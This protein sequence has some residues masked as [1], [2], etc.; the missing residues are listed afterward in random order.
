MSGKLIMCQGLPGSG[1]TTWANEQV[2]A[3][4][5]AQFVPWPNVVGDPVRYTPN[6]VVVCRDDIRR[7]LYAVNGV[8]SWR[9]YAMTPEQE[10][11]VTLVQRERIGNAL[12]AGKAV[13]SADTNISHRARTMLS[14]LA[15]EFGVTLEVKQFL[16]DPEECIRR[17]ALRGNESVGADVIR[18]MAKQ[19]GVFEEPKVTP[20]VCKH[21]V[22]DYWVVICDIDGTLA[23]HTSRSPYD[24]TRVSTDEVNSEV[25]TLVSS[26]SRDYRI[27]YM[28][29][30]HEGCRVD[31]TNWL[32][33]HGLPYGPVYMRPDGDS[34]KD[35]IVKAELFDRYVR[36]IANVK[37][38]LDDRDQVVRMWRAM[39]LTCLQVADGK[40]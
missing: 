38:V 31:T 39:G 1:K 19:W 4:R 26:I 7:E 11:H 40:F 3:D 6:V 25:A 23:L 17:D 29:G 14:Q 34:R 27:L 5:L 28:T 30:R 20:Y 12:T 2:E 32:R 36:D 37:F 9:T 13:I 15:E 35:W 22:E 24:E 10:D 33:V 8:F 18:K 16:T 21:G